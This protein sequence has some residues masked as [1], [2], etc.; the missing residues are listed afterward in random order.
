M[1]R[2]T[3]AVTFTIITC[4]AISG[5]DLTPHDDK[6]AS[7]NWDDALLVTRIEVA[8]KK[9][10]YKLYTEKL[11]LDQWATFMKN[12]ERGSGVDVTPAPTSEEVFIF[13]FRG[14][15]VQRYVVAGGALLSSED[16]SVCAVVN[17]S[18]PLKEVLPQST[19]ALEEAWATLMTQLLDTPNKQN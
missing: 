8:T 14:S 9:T 10:S 12:I 5:G 17:P 3:I 4:A 19:L 1:P 16:G 6:G 15:Q 11:I 2:I 13:S 7:S 18:L